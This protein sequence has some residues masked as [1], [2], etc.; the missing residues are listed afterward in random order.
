MDNNLKLVLHRWYFLTLSIIPFHWAHSQDF[1]LSPPQVKIGAKN[2][3]NKKLGS[4]QF[5]DGEWLGYE[6]KHGRLSVRMEREQPVSKV[7]ISALEDPGSYIFF[8]K[9]IEF[10][11]SKDGKKFIS[12]A[13]ESYE[14]AG[15]SNGS[16]RKNFKL[17]FEEE[18]KRWVKI[19]VLS[20]L[21]NPDWHPAPG[22][23]CWIFLDEILLN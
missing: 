16:K 17:E 15:A 12:V 6:G 3:A 5:S 21:T 1:Q 9:E 14:S 10:L 19:N 4:L 23:K 22:A 11:I 18:D 13:K 8:P 2:L 7:I 20:H